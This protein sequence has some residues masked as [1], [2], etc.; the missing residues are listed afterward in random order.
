MASSY[1]V[2]S[3]G[4]DLP[5][6]VLHGLPH[7]DLLAELYCNLEEVCT[8]MNYRYEAD[9][10]DGDDDLEKLILSNM[11]VCV[12]NRLFVNSECMRAFIDEQ[13]NSDMVNRLVVWLES[14]DY[15][16]SVINL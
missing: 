6:P 8:Q 7:V 4:F 2:P 10:L 14:R 3:I 11:C 9:E 12:Q 5:T 15:L 16:P 1:T 13:K